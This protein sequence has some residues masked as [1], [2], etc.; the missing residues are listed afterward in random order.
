MLSLLP[1]LRKL[2]SP[3]MG[4]KF[5]SDKFLLT[6]KGCYFL[7]ISLDCLVFVMLQIV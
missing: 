1:K 6:D 3:N 4:K 5:F 2:I 7:C